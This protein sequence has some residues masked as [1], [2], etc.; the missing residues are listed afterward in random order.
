MVGFGCDW[1]FYLHM[2]DGIK[3]QTSNGLFVMHLNYWCLP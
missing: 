3:V 2:Q 1:A